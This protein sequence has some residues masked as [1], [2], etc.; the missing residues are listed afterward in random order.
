M[1]HDQEKCGE[2]ENEVEIFVRASAFVLKSF[3]DVNGRFFLEKKWKKKWLIE[4]SEKK[5]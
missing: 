3:K 2:S 4:I 1:L 5:M